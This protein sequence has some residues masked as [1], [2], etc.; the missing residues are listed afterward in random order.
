MPDK[1]GMPN[2]RDHLLAT[3]RFKPASWNGGL[4][5]LLEITSDGGTAT[6]EFSFAKDSD[7]EIILINV[8]GHVSITE[9]TKNW[10]VK[11]GRRE[12]KNSAMAKFAKNFDDDA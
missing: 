8:G 5:L 11:A 1:T 6:L 9:E 3:G 2:L 4:P 7:G 12:A 10:Y